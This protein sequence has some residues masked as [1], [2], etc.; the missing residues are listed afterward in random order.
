LSIARFVP[1]IY[2]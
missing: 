1:K 2:A